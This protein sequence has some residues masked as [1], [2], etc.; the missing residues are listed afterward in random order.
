M[1]KIF[2]LKCQVTLQCLLDNEEISPEPVFLIA[3]ILMWWLRI[4]YILKLF[5]F[6]R[7]SF[8][9]RYTLL[10]HKGINTITASSS[11]LCSTPADEITLDDDSQDL[12]IPSSKKNGVRLRKQSKTPFDRKG[13]ICRCLAETTAF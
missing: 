4:K 1:K 2:R 8:N 5:H 11:G 7:H 10:C 9:L 13:S 12:R 3:V 6:L